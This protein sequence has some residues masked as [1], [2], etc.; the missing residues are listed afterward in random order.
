[1]KIKTKLSLGLGLLLALILIL[2]SIGTRQVKVLSNDTENILV[3][4]YNT[5]DYARKMLVVLDELPLDSTSISKFELNLKKQQNNITEIGEK[6]LTDKLSQDLDRL[7]LNYQSSET[8]TLIRKDLTDIMFLNML[9]I[10]RKSNVAKTTAKESTWW[11]A[12]TGA[13]CLIIAFTLFVNLPGSIANPIKE[14]TASIKQ[15]AAMNYSERVHFKSNSEFG[16]LANSFNVMA[17]KLE[18]YNSSNLSKLMIEKKRVETLVD[19]MHD[20]VIGLDE[21]KKVLFANHEAVKILGINLENL[22]GKPAEE[23][24]VTNDLMRSLLQELVAKINSHTS[25]TPLKIYANNKESYFEKEIVDISI[26]PTGEPEA[27]HIGHFIVLKNITPFKELDFA[28]TNFIATIS[29]ELKTPISAI[30]LSL[31]LLENKSTGQINTEQKQLLESI[32][33]DSNRLLKI[34]GELLNLSQVE[35]GN[36]Q[37]NIQSCEAKQIVQYAIETVKTT[38]DQKQITLLVNIDPGLKPVKADSE[39]TAWVLVNLLTNAIRYSKEKS[40]I[41][42]EA[43]KELEKVRFSVTDHGQGIDAKYLDKLFNRYFQVPGSNTSGTG[44]GL[45]ISKEFIEAQGGEITVE[46]TIGLG[47]KFS[48]VLNT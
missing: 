7:K 47:S 20:P 24:A 39:K 4:N 25:Q 17:K 2:S 44:L 16:E 3:A 40:R 48:F 15:I 23:I 21:K 19:N 45:S 14:L 13:I 6:E 5:L 8:S 27:K 41:S 42:I 28:K 22:I 29:H 11:I 30:K 46:S 35:T 32:K 10:E 26:I 18:E 38:A 37:L 33:D 36:I 1:M 43:N 31:Q 12:I 34:T 9:A